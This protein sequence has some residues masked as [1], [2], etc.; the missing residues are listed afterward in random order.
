MEAGSKIYN[1]GKCIS[2]SCAEK[3][4]SN[5]RHSFP[6]I[7]IMPIMIIAIERM[8]YK[9]HSNMRF[10]YEMSLDSLITWSEESVW[11]K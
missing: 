3:L 10:Q 7:S 1:N 4:E 6:F 8:V 11:K 2:I 5:N 9:K